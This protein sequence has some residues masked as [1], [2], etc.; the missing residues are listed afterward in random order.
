MC[1]KEETGF[2]IR[3]DNEIPGWKLSPGVETLPGF[4]TFLGGQELGFHSFLASFLNRQNQGKAKMGYHIV[5]GAFGSPGTRDPS[6]ERRLLLK[7]FVM[8]R[9]LYS[10]SF[11]DTRSVS[12]VRC[13]LFSVNA[14][15]NVRDD[16]YC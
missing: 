13:V 1:G 11:W 8:T 3:K 4:G 14:C 12:L 6:M 2:R 15:L 16:V 10:V 7:T 5:R 9:R